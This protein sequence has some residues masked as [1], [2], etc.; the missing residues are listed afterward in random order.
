MRLRSSQAH[1]APSGPLSLAYTKRTQRRATEITGDIGPS[2]RVPVF[3]QLG[4]SPPTSICQV[5]L[6]PWLV[7]STIEIPPRRVQSLVRPRGEKKHSQPE[8]EGST[9]SRKSP[10]SR[11]QKAKRKEVIIDSKT[12]DEEG[13][14][15]QSGNPKS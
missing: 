7:K 14:V 10:R 4:P 1:P 2:T 8:L 6:S 13:L 11:H 12:S 3:D 15:A 5:N 9:R